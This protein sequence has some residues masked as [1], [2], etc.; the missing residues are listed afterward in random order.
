VAPRRVAIDAT[1]L[2][3][4]R[5]GVARFASALLD[6]VARRD[7]VTAVAFAITW[8]GRGELADL[9]PAGVATASGPMAAAPLRALWRRTD[10][11]RIERWTGHV[12]VVHGPNFVVPPSAGPRVATVHDLTFIHHPELCTA[13][14][15]QYPDLIRRAI[16]AG[17]WIHTPSRFVADEVIEVF[18]AD[19]DRVVAV[20][21]GV[22]RPPSADAAGGRALAGG[23]RYLLAL[24]T[25]E[26]RKNLPGLVAAF[27][28]LAAQDDDLRLVVAGPDGWGVEAYE[29]AVR[30]A[31]HAGRIVRL[32]F[33]S[34]VDRGDLLA[35]ASAVA[36]PSR[37]EGFG[38]VAAE[39]ML[40]GVPV[41]ASDAGSH[42]EIVGDAGLLVPAADTDALAAALQSVLADDELADEL[43]RRGPV[44]AAQL[45]WAAA[46]DGVVDVWR[47]ATASS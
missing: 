6:Q 32:G 31:H 2:Y 34:E 21:N 20:P 38:L 23:A 12:D 26:P 37:Y 8:R 18:G 45:T 22:T 33:V 35:G 39:A 29:A 19:P 43:R 41:V 11:P 9:V 3:G 15:L 40:A 25:V 30:R 17:A 36:V 46:A 24:G 4:A 44:R 27:D 10:H 14:V 28:G 16:H 47:R 5:T 7:D 42:P 13:D 1:S